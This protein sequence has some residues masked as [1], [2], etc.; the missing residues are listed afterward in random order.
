MYYIGDIC[1]ARIYFEGTS[2]LFKDRPVL[3]LNSDGKGSYTIVEITS[4]APKDPPGYYDTFKE[5]IK[6]WQ[7]YGLDEPSWVKCKNVHN[8]QNLKFF[9][10]IGTMKNTEEFER[11]VDRIDEYN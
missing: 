8:P 7:K 5:E 2:G 3:I 10:K 4:V 6:D 9:G 11:I 1:I